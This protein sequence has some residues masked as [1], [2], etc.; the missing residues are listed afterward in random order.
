MAG[1]KRTSGFKSGVRDCVDSDK[2]SAR[3]IVPG[4]WAIRCRETLGVGRSRLA[5]AAARKISKGS[6]IE[7][8]SIRGC[9]NAATVKFFLDK[10][11]ELGI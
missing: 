3:V 1:T 11:C 8:A 10:A 6:V 2:P 5:W 4:V 7:V 9:A